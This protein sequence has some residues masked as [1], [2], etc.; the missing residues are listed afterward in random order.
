MGRGLMNSL[1]EKTRSNLKGGQKDGGLEE[2]GGREERLQGRRVKRKRV[3]IKNP[4]TG[5]KGRNWI[6]RDRRVW[7]I[8]ICDQKIGLKKS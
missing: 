4:D 5:K 2:K 8:C 1:T 7:T 3:S 6:K